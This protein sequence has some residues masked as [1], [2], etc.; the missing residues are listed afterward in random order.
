M[1]KKTHSS[2]NL[3]AADRR[4]SKRCEEQRK[5][6]REITESAYEAG[7]N[8]DKLATRLLEESPIENRS[9]ARGTLNR[10]QRRKILKHERA[11]GSTSDLANKFPHATREEKGLIR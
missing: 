9:S 1:A 6:L 3:L 11:H 2:S 4:L 8:L 5:L 10:E 7:A